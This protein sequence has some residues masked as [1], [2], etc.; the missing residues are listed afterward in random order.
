MIFNLAKLNAEN[1]VL[2]NED[3]QFVGTELEM[4]SF[5]IVVKRLTR[6]DKINVGADSADENGKISSGEYSKAMFVNSITEVDGFTDENQQ[7]ISIENSVRELIWEY[8]PD[9]MVEAIKKAIESFDIKDEKKSEEQ[10]A[11]SLDIPTGS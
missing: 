7:P 2:S 5:M 8:S 3:E 6:A 10:E 11:P 1:V 4:Q 9:V